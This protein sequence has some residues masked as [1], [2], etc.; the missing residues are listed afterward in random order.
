M[1]GGRNQ[2]KSITV[3]SVTEPRIDA[4]RETD[5]ECLGSRRNKNPLFCQGRLPVKISERISI[6]SDKQMTPPF[7]QKAKK[8]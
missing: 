4:R 6:T 7:W 5:T 3:S 1:V 2:N 8:N